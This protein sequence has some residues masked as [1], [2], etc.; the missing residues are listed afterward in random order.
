MIKKIISTGTF[1]SGMVM[2]FSLLPGIASEAWAIALPNV[3]LGM[4]NMDE[5]ETLSTALQILFLLT[6]L[7]LAPSI[8][9][10]TTSFSRI[11][12]V[13][14]FLRQAMGTQQTPPTQVLIGLA[15]FLTFFVMSPVISDIN[16]T[17]FQPYMNEEISQ[18]EAFDRAQV[19]VKRFMLRQTREKDL[20]LFV[21]IAHKEAPVTE[22][23]IGLNVVIPAFVTVAVYIDTDDFFL[24]H[25]HCF[26]FP[27]SSHGNSAN[28][29]DPGPDWP[30]PVSHVFCDE[31]RY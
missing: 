24:P 27:A 4:E 29:S 13:L 22:D 10:L 12:I 16:D 9:I 25:Y 8:L 28:S 20:A 19:P 11:I 23:E 26:V 30:G 21:N 18:S 6:V 2:A 17:A 3:Q 14:S 31:S 7:T 5:P 1:I 15:L